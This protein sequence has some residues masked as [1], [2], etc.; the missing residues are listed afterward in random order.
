VRPGGALL[1]DAPRL[2]HLRALLG[3][4]GV[5][6]FCHGGVPDRASGTCLDDNVRALLVAV[7][8]LAAG[9]E[10]ESARAI[11]DAAIAFIESARRPDGRYHNMADIDGAF[12]D[13]VGS[14][15]SFGRM[16]WACG[17]T[18]R[19]A[20]PGAWREAAMSTVV[21]ALP[22]IAEL[23][24]VHPRAYAALG[25]AAAIAPECASLGAPAVGDVPADANDALTRGLIDVADALDAQ[26][27]AHATTDWS[28]WRPSLTWGCGRLPAAMIAAALA[29]GRAR[30][31]HTGMRAL[32]FLAG[33]TQ[34]GDRFIP[35]GNDGWYERG[36]PR[37]IY[38]QQPIEACAMV[39]AWLAAH[40][41]TGDRWYADQ[42]RTAFE[43]Y[44]GRNTE[45]LAVALPD[46][47]GCHDGLGRA[48]LN[49][50]LGAES[51]LSYLHAAFAIQSV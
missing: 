30:Y 50:D 42:A 12:L 48:W 21:L 46:I 24:A 38:D 51:T 28:W 26:F 35:I 10:R 13:D 36:G 40:R 41:F 39:D 20:E 4:A 37:A 31:A 34:D 5:V 9:R 15:D 44:L 19:C 32:A 25:L 6:Q 14:E 23:T 2:D 16:I 7:R 18:A 49:P 33:V 45:R 22:I 17:V 29:T 27:H 47:G 8:A 1:V 43:W 3:P 11:G